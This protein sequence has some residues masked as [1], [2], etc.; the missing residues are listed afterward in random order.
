M[1]NVSSK[2]SLTKK[3]LVGYAMGDLGGCMTFAILGSFLTPYYTE[4]AGLTTGAVATMYL[5]LKIWDAINDPMMGALLDK[6][7]ARTHSPKGKFRPWMFRATPLLAICAV[8]MW[9]A[10]TYVNGAAKIVVAFVTYLLYE[11]CYTM[12]NIPYGSLLSAM[13]GND[14]ERASL[15][16]ARG[17]GSMIG[18]L[19]PMFI[20][21]III[22]ASEANPQ[23]GYTA[24]ITACAA[25]GF[26]ACLLSCKWTTEE[27]NADVTEDIQDSSD[28][29][30]SDILVVIRKNRAFDAL[31]LQGLFYCIA[32]YM[33][34]TLGVYM[35]RDVLGNVALM[36]LTM[37]I[38]MPLSFL[39]LGLAP[40]IS[41]KFG[42]ERTVRASQL[43]SV[44]LYIVVFVLLL[45]SSNVVLYMTMSSLASGFGSLTVLMQWGMVGEAIDYNEYLTGKRTEGSIY[46][47]FNLTRRIGQAVGSSVAVALLGVVGYVPNAAAQTAGAILGIKCLVVLAPCLFI[48]LCWASLRF[49]WNITPEIR[50]KMSASKAA[51]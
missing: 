10:P 49:V 9:T 5:I 17:F 13:S 21:P 43:I 28:I 6:V 38:S 12:F 1:E 11:A 24:G 14:K 48:L 4:V 47:T 23:F 29:K 33:G 30:F 3:N 35:Y 27:K 37:V 34:S 7:F 8:F 50:E 32:Q 22:K 44:A 20:F 42:L 51:K 2:S 15:S 45:F 19:I 41:G 40:K 25:V 39:F 36:S 16:S 31:C 18:N 46:G 26:I